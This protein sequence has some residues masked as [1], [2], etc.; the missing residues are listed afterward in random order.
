MRHYPQPDSRSCNDILPSG[1]L[2]GGVAQ[3]NRRHGSHVPEQWLIF[4]RII[5]GNTIDCI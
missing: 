2:S 4:I 5:Q 3:K 1:S